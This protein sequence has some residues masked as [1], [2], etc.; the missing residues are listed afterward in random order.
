MDKESSLQNVTREPAKPALPWCLSWAVPLAGLMFALACGSPTR[1]AVPAGKL[2]LLDAQ[3]Q[4]VAVG[5]VGWEDALYYHED[6]NAIPYTGPIEA[7]YTNNT[8]HM[9][10]FV[11]E[12][13]LDGSSIIWFDN[14]DQEQW[15][16]VYQSGRIEAFKEY[17]QNGT[18]VVEYPLPT[19]PGSTN[20][21]N[22]NTPPITS[23][24]NE[25]SLAQLQLRGAVFCF[26][27][28]LLPI[29]FNGTAIERWEDGTIK[30]R[31]TF[32]EGQHHGLVEWWHTNGKPWFRATFQNGLPEGRV[33][34]WRE[35][36]TRE[37]VYVWNGLPESRITYAPDGTESGRVE[38]DTGTLIYYHPNGTKKLEEVYEGNPLAPSKRIWY[39]ETGMQIDPPPQPPDAITPPGN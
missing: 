13:R 11:R 26:V 1:P 9:L 4:P 15:N 32:E 17:D 3:G 16:I 34:A 33:E 6:D 24:T 22:T 20:V 12:G 28:Q 23:G 35:D 37:Y 7:S 31:E 29:A 14:N 18:V 27:G 8:K 36:G 5:N 21:A 38:N 10:A 19:I 30:K 25:V 39:D 2:Q